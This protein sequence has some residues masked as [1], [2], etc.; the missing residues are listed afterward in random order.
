[1]FLNNSIIKKY[2]KCQEE[3]ED[4]V[5]HAQ[6]VLADQADQGSSGSAVG[7]KEMISHHNL[8]TENRL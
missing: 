1:M 3:E 4:Q 2:P 7:H 5:V 6:E 8:K